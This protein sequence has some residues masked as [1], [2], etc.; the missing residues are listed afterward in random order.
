MISKD[1]FEN[2]SKKRQNVLTYIIHCVKMWSNNTGGNYYETER[3]QKKTGNDC[4]SPC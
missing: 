4:T 3:N 2:E 1:F